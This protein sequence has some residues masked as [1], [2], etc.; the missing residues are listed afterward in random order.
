MKEKKRK[1]RWRR[2][3]QERGVKRKIETIILNRRMRK[4]KKKTKNE[5]FVNVL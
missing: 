1:M 2:K 5:C 4:G 3:E